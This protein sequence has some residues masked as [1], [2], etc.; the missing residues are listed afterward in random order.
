M[1]LWFEFEKGIPGLKAKTN[2]FDTV[3][4]WDD[5]EVGERP[6][7]NAGQPTWTYNYGKL[8][9]RFGDDFL[10]HI[11]ACVG[12]VTPL[13]ELEDSEDW[14]A[15]TAYDTFCTVLQ[16]K[17]WMTTQWKDSMTTQE[18]PLTM[19]TFQ[20]AKFFVTDAEDHYIFLYDDLSAKAWLESQIDADDF[21]RYVNDHHYNKVVGHR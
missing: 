3:R 6:D 18:N 13:S 1:S 17:I 4:V 10:A 12:P 16:S 14:S 7:D 21:V 15:K 2:I 19:G 5:N 20:G 8:I 9:M 11:A